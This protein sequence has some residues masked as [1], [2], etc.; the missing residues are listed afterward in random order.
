MA[1]N[2]NN[3][4]C[5]RRGFLRVMAGVP[6]AVAGLA[7]GVGYRAARAT[8]APVEPSPDE[9]PSRGYHE[10]AHIRRYYATARR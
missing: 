2:T 9:S 10:T 5:K 4:F 7:G 8:G 3:A 1:G 6:F